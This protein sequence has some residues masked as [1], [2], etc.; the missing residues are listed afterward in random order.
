V[1]TPCDRQ[2]NCPAGCR[3]QSRSKSRWCVPMPRHRMPN[4]SPRPWLT[5]GGTLNRAGDQG[6]PDFGCRFRLAQR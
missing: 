6:R 3:A 2:A 4:A 1:C 5:Y